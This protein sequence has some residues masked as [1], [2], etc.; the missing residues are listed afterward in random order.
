M[1]KA[2]AQFQRWTNGDQAAEFSGVI[3]DPPRLTKTTAS[4]NESTESDEDSEGDITLQNVSTQTLNGAV[5]GEPSSSNHL[6][7]TGSRRQWQH[8]QQAPN[9]LSNMPGGSPTTD[10]SIHIWPESEPRKGSTRSPDAKPLE[11][12]PATSPRQLARESLAKYARLQ[13]SSQLH[14]QTSNGLSSQRSQSL[15]PRRNL[16]SQFQAAAATDLE[17]G[18]PLG[19]SDKMDSPLRSGHGH[20]SS[21][22]RYSSR[23]GLLEGQEGL[24]STGSRNRNI[25]HMPAGR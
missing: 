23:R 4:G 12:K 22:S 20:L 11:R 6:G 5:D 2:A 13:S 19:S 14:L 3:Q 9:L 21:S 1:M 18:S 17:R 25:T 8:P 7:G 10:S 16:A 15:S 24:S